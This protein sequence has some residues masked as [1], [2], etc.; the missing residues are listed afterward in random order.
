MASFI[1]LINDLLPMIIP[2]SVSVTK[3][4]ALRPSGATLQPGSANEAD[5]VVSKS[6]KLCASVLTLNAHATSAIRHHG[7][8]DTIVYVASGTGLLLVSP[9][10]GQD[11][12]RHEM[13]TGDFAF[14]PSWTEHQM[15]NESDDDAVWVI[16]RSGSQPVNVGL[17]DWGGDEAK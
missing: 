14:I 7:E 10:A 1:P 13:S 6:D 12:K 17:T 11:V 16:T 5:A 15:L 8:Q 9:G 4:S 2:S 3:A